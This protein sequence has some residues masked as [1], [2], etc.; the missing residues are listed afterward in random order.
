M[1][2]TVTNCN[3]SCNIQGEKEFFN[4]INVIRLIIINKFFFN[5][6]ARIKFLQS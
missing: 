1:M 2:I 5:I 3:C 4:V 6:H